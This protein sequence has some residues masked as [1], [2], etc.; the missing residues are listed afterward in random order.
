[1]FEILKKFEAK[2]APLQKKG[3]RVNGFTIIDVRKKTHAIKISRPFIFDNRLVP[4]RYEGVQVKSQIQGDLPE[5]FTFDRSNPDWAKQNYIW[6]PERFEKF[7]DRCGE[8]I[9]IKLENP[10]MNRKEMLDALCFGDF[11]EHKL[12]SMQLIKEGKLPAYKK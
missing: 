11:E 7:V 3:M 12:K 6:A 9:K 5:E 4:K 1:M 8:E 2:Y 10:T